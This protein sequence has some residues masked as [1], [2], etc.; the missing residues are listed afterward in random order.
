MTAQHWRSLLQP[1][2]LAREALRDAYRKALEASGAVTS[3]S[4]HPA[5][6]LRLEARTRGGH[7]LTI[8]LDNLYADVARSPPAARARLVELAL[9]ASVESAKAADGEVAAPTREQL[10][11]TI[12][13]VAWLQSVPVS[14][15]AKDFLAGDLTVVYAFD[16]A[17]SL[18][19][20]RIP[21]LESLGVSPAMALA[22]A[23]A[24]LRAR[25]P[26][27][28]DTRGD[29]RSFMLLAGGNYEASLLLLDEIWDQFAPRLPGRLLA[30][31]P[32][33]DVCL[34][35]STETPGGVASLI[36]ARDRVWNS[37]PSHAIAKT[38]LQ[39]EDRNWAVAK[40]PDSE[41]AR[42]SH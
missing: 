29:G 1:A 2:A 8:N 11:P 25:L 16:R 18:V 20:A 28:L 23:K 31:V 42:S 36:A 39:R 5:D 24:N 30:C 41:L 6:P 35:T 38:L 13:N 33:R 22:L 10:V 12:R 40:I 19:P 14:D 26:P 37:A 21:E 3:T 15:L 9:A 27:S 32:A 4:A 34:V 7:T 17:H